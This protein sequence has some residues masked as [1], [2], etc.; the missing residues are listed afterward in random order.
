MII[1]HHLSC[2]FGRPANDLFGNLLA[3]VYNPPPQIGMHYYLGHSFRRPA[4]DSFDDWLANIYNPPP[5]NHGYL[6]KCL[7]AKIGERTPKITPTLKKENCS[8]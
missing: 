2:S 3:N 8:Q 6:D 1:L 7:P 4:N 5:Q